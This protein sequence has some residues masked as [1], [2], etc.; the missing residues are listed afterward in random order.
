MARMN[1]SG[2]QELMD[3]LFRESE[4]VQQK[5][6]PMLEAAAGVVEG[7]WKQAITEAGHAP[8]G[9]SGRATGALLGSIRATAMKKKDD[10]YTREIYPQGKDRHG[11]RLAEVAFVLHYGNS[12]MKGDHFVDTAEAKAEG[13][14]QAVMEEVWNRD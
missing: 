5:A 10:A 7:S 1:F 11:E 4:R 8:P 13:A 12:R 3:E 14:V 6:G 9:K 2:T